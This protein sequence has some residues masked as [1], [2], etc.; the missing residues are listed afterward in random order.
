VNDLLDRA[1]DKERTWQIKAT[2]SKYAPED[3]EVYVQKRRLPGV[4]GF[5]RRRQR[6][7]CHR[8]R[9]TGQMAGWGER[10]AP[11]RPIEVQ[12]SLHNLLVNAGIQRLEDLLIGAGGTA[13]N[14]ANSRIG[15]GNSSTAAVATQTDLQAA[16]GAANRQFKLISSAVS[17]TTNTITW[18][19]T[20]ASGEAQFVWNE[21]CIDN[22]TADG[23]TV[24]APMLNRKVANPGT[25]GAAVWVFTVTLTIS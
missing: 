23:T 6:V 14:T 22:G 24:V 21:W 17:R 4:R 10:C 16:A 5:V 25:K 19:A 1:P 12:T 9:G 7:T 18:V 2:V 15:V 8:V 11:A 13:Y 20:F 3:V